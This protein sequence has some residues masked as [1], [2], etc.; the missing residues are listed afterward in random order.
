MNRIYDDLGHF[1][2]LLLGIA[3]WPY[4]PMVLSG[5]VIARECA[6][7]SFGKT[8]L[9][10]TH[11]TSR[12]GRVN[13]REPRRPA[14]PRMDLRVDP[15]RLDVRIRQKAV[16]VLQPI[17]SYALLNRAK[18]H[19]QRYARTDIHGYSTHDVQVGGNQR[20]GLIDFPGAG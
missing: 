6:I 17:Q 20:V 13:H 19:V 3:Q 1:E 9:P 16:R 14:P 10:N 12:K 5:G 18:Y 15:G 2:A 7:D 4:P 11:H 8:R